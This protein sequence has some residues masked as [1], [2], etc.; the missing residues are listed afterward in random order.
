M[1]LEMM[2][3]LNF[4]FECEIYLNKEFPNMGGHGP[5]RKKVGIIFLYKNWVRFVIFKNNKVVIVFS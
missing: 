2:L 3:S 4:G 5:E 1:P